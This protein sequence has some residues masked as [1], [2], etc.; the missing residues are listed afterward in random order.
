MKVQISSWRL[1][2]PVYFMI[3][4]FAGASFP[5]STFLA[6][7]L[8]SIVVEISL[9]WKTALAILLAAFCCQVATDP[10]AAMFGKMLRDQTRSRLGTLAYKSPLGDWFELQEPLLEVPTHPQPQ[11]VQVISTSMAGNRFKILDALQLKN[12]T[13]PSDVP[14]ILLEP[15][16][17]YQSFLGFGGSFTESSADLFHQMAPSMQERILQAYFSQDKGLAYSWG[18]V[19]M[20]SC[21]FSEGNWSC[22]AENDKELKTFNIERYRRSILPM[23]HKAQRVRQSDKA[24]SNRAPDLHLLASPWSPPG[25]M[26]DS[27]QMLNGGSLL[28]EFRSSWAKHFVRFAEAFKSEGLPL[29][30]FTVQNEPRAVT[31]WE[32]CLYTAEEERDFVRDHLGPALTASGLDLKLLIWDH[33]RDN[34][35]LRAHTIYSDPEA[36]KYVWGTGYHW[37][38]DT[39]YE[40]WPAREGMLLFDN[41]RKVHELWPEKHIIM[42]ESCQESGPRIGDWKLGERYAEAI[43]EDLENWLEAWIDWNLILD[44]AGGHNHVQNLVS[45]PVIYDTARDKLVFLSSF[46]YIGHFSRYIIRGAQRIAVAT[47]RDALK[48]T[49]FRNPDGGLVVVVLNQEDYGIKF[50]LKLGRRS[51]ETEIPARSITT[52]RFHP[53]DGQS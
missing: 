8:P 46:Y 36:A 12:Q 47:N 18:R 20:G 13:L 27:G 52:Y 24:A 10:T 11:R 40:F 49:G 6:I 22:V 14:H 30:G 3:F 2:A 29:W 5:V 33:N 17:R 4:H 43:I 7:L 45:A 31:P 16:K 37:Y 51:A 28:P 41:L 9:N 23:L 26:K 42:T 53:D 15:S 1:L 21:D 35:F 48:T 25:W 38:G 44:E 19:H 34:M 50:W 39:R 32:N